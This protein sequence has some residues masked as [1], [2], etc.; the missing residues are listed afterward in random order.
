VKKQELAD[1]DA[2]SL[3]PVVFSFQ[4]VPGDDQEITDG[5][6]EIAIDASTRIV[7]SA[8]MKSKNGRNVALVPSGADAGELEKLSR[9]STHMMQAVK[10]PVALAEANP[11]DI[12]TGAPRKALGRVERRAVP[13]S[14]AERARMRRQSGDAVGRFRVFWAEASNRARGITAALFGAFGLG[15]LGLL[16]W[17]LKPPPDYQPPPEPTE[18]TGTPIQESFGLGTGVTYE[19]PDQKLFNFEFNT[20]A[21]QAIVIVRFQSR[22]IGDK[23]VMLS[24][25][26]ADIEELKADGTDQDEKSHEIKVPAQHLEKGKPN[27]I[28]FDNVKN[29]PGSDPWRIWNVWIEVATIPEVPADQLNAEANARFQKGIQ[30][31]DRREIGAE[32]TYQAY[33]AFREAWLLLEGASGKKPELHAIARDKMR[34]TQVELNKLCQR[35]LLEGQRHIALKKYKD[36]RSSFEEVKRFFPRNDQPCPGRAEF[37]IYR[38]EL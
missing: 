12:D 21:K 2:V 28:A 15:V 1:G 16:I 22:D 29:P 32:N 7:A 19:R 33:R 35:L 10:K 9:K 26:G 18:L 14:A 5:K 23:E 11:D 8:D 24:V 27:K 31:Y 3:G 20:P 34:E 17:A 4:A 30:L 38:N 13:L 37:E 25:N 36:A 6:V